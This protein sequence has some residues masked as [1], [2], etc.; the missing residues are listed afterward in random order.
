MATHFN[1]TTLVNS[2]LTEKQFIHMVKTNLENYECVIVRIHGD[3][4]VVVGVTD[5]PTYP[6]TLGNGEQANCGY[7]PQLVET[8]RPRKEFLAQR[9]KEL[10]L[11][12]DLVM[13]VLSLIDKTMYEDFEYI[14]HIVKLLKG[15]SDLYL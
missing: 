1:A 6:L 2:S 10:G 5:D 14:D 3:L 12:E 15:D 7:S 13:P 8:I 4:E 9:A 11:P